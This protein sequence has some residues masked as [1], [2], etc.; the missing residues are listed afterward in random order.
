MGF[1]LPVNFRSP[2]KARNVGEFGTLAHQSV[3]WLKDYLYTPMGGNRGASWFTFISGR[4]CSTLSCFGYAGV[5]PL[6]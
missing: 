6:C 4:F 1:H 5:R 3:H 2:Y